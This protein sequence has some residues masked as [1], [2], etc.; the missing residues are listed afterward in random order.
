MLTETIPDLSPI[1]ACSVDDQISLM[2]AAIGPI[3][4]DT[5]GFHKMLGFSVC[6]DGLS[7]GFYLPFNHARDNLSDSQRRKVFEILNE[8]EALVA[9]NAI[10]DL[11]VFAR[12]GFD[13]RGKFYD[14]MLMAHWVN[15]ERMNYSLDKISPIYGG[16]P[17][18]MPAVMSMIID[19]E[20]WDA[21]PIKW[22]TIYSGNDAYIEHQ[23][24]NQL[25]PEFR[26]Q[27]FDGELWDYEQKFIRDVMGPM[28]ER[29]V[30]LNPEFCIRE[31][32]KGQ[33]VMEDCRKELGYSTIGPKALE[34]IFIDKLRLPVVKVTPGGKPSFD[35]E[36]MER[37]EVLL[38]KS[39]NPV[40]QTVLRY[41][42]WQKTI[43]ANYKAY[44]EFADG[45]GILHPGYKLHGTRTG[46][47]SCEKPALHQ[48]PKSS[49]KEWN[50]HS[51]NA[52]IARDGYS[53]WT[54]DYSQLQFRMTCSYAKQYD[55]IEIFNDPDRDIFTEM[56][57]EMGWLRDDVKTLVYLILFGGG[58][59]RAKDAFG[60]ATV[61]AGKALVDE[62]HSMYPN[63]KKI[64]RQAQNFAQKFKF[65]QYWTGRRR[66]FFSRDAKFYR[67][68]NAVIQGGEAEIMKRAMIACQEE[69]CND[70]CNM[71][72]QIHDELAFE[73]KDGMETH[74]LPRL[75]AVMERIP[76]ED[77][78][79]FTGTPVSFR[80]SVKPWGEK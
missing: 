27:G 6:F 26:E 80:T 1:Q 32:L 47:L 62:F 75:Q 79:A 43:S 39:K 68:F 44:L 9:Y 14:P 38:E 20:G 29:G 63:I 49:N 52:F 25:L 5:E 70:D 72:L 65:V 57:K 8:A 66:H 33:V 69:I 24:L 11:R 22:M 34:E 54:I 13:Y 61:E 73:I 12:N 10:H 23:L 31:I 59:T 77:F 16:K 67:A 46:R 55:L 71:V 41:R 21:V 78:C 37:Y 18:Q 76:N 2:E 7:D 17:K 19:Q 40:A 35:K 58:A 42:G 53:L 50:G 60:L 36:A 64:A 15:E 45:E 30:R 51:K 74:Y 48:I 28:I 4:V 3:T 56:A